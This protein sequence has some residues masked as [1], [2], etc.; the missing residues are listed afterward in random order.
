VVGNSPHTFSRERG[1]EE[2]R[3]QR[4]KLQYI[5]WPIV[6]QCNDGH[7]MVSWIMK[8]GDG[9]EAYSPRPPNFGWKVTPN[10]SRMLFWVALPKRVMR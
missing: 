2:D 9:P 4:S 7:A 5:A 3:A 6:A 10:A 1:V 8:D